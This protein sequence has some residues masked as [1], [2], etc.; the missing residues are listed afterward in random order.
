MRPVEFLGAT[1][2]TGSYRVKCCYFLAIEEIQRFAA[3]CAG[4]MATGGKGSLAESSEVI[5]TFYVKAVSIG[6]AHT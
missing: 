1:S 5:L 6:K 2:S 3:T 4:H